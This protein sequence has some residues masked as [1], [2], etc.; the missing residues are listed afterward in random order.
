MTG[1]T[2]SLHNT[3]SAAVTVALSESSF[4]FVLRGTKG[5]V[6]DS[7]I[8][9]QGGSGPAPSPTRI[10]A[11][12]TR[13]FSPADVW[14]RWS[15]P[16]SIKPTC[17]GETLPT[18]RTVVAAPGPAPDETQAVADVVAAAGHLF[19]KCRPVRARV[20][21]IGTIDPPSGTAPAMHAACSIDLR[22]EG[23]FWVA[24]TL[25]LIPPTLR[26]VKVSEPY[27]QLTMPVD[28]SSAEAI[29]WE[30]VDTAKGALP[31]ATDTADTTLPSSA[32]AP[33]WSWTGTES[34]SRGRYRCG[35]ELSSGGASPHAY[36]EFISVC[37]S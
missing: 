7:S 1:L 18:L 28:S 9:I 24:Q 15:G 8:A 6:Y 17:V 33:N 29:A 21:V 31:V 2:F 32:M 25:V 12:A 37:P 14:L 4:G 3:T 13:K 20:P 11:G 16:L 36:I 27:E 5:L 35:G 23:F 34:E 10:P 19:D 22:R 26:G 30:F